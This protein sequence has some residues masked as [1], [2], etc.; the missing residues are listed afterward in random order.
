M[1]AFRE[2]H[3]LG[4]GQEGVLGRALQFLAW[5]KEVEVERR[6]RAVRDRW[7]K[8]VGVVGSMMAAYGKLT[9]ISCYSIQ[10]L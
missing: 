8:L 5:P 7:K 2:A 9:I 4:E 6:M 1:V 3:S 10:R